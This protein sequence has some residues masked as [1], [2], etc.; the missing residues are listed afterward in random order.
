MRGDSLPA[1]QN[2]VRYV[3]GTKIQG[4]TVHPGGFDDSPISVNWLECVSGSKSEQVERVRGL[5]RLVRGRTAGFAEL[6]VGAVRNLASNLD[7]LED[8]L[9]ATSTWP[10]APCHAEIV[11]L[12]DDSAQRKLVCEQLADSVVAVHPAYADAD[13]DST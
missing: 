1:T 6:N 8:P 4:D 9:D 11:G 3:G 13:E 10:A 2:V 7:V 12:A 5:L